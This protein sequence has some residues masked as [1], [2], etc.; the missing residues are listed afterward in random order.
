[1]VLTTPLFDSKGA[2]YAHIVGW[3]PHALRIYKTRGKWQATAVFIIPTA[4][5]KA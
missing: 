4:H 5:A 1:M 3:P 2:L